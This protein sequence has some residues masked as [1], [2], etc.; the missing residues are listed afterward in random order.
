MPEV[1]GKKQGW[2]NG[3]WTQKHQGDP[4]NDHLGA[5]YAIMGL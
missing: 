5:G 3:Q 4:G 1:G 2:G